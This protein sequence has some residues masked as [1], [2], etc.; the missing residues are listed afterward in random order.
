MTALSVL[1]ACGG[2]A[3]R[4]A[5]DAEGQD[6][7]EDSLAILQQEQKEKS[8]MAKLENLPE[9][10]VFVISTSLG[11]ITVKL[12]ADTPLHRDNF[13]KLAFEGY[14]DGILFHRVIPDFMIQAGDPYSKDPQQMDKVGTGGPGYT[15]PAEIVPGHRHKK[16]ALAAARRGDAAN[17]TKAS[18]GSQFYIVQSEEGC[19]HL[20]GGYTIFGETVDGFEVIDKIASVETD[21]RRGIP[22]TPVTI[23]NIRLQ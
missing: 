10:P 11:D 8:V 16:G 14:Y 1:S 22:V 6:A 4:S 21:G 13:A 7:R 3:A 15:V 23:L 5:K 19:S 18:S 20:D 2:R 9:E 12:Y 17:P